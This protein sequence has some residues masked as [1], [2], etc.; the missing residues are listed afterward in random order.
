MS[1]KEVDL[2]VQIVDIGGKPLQVV[3]HACHRVLEHMVDRR[4]RRRR[5][6]PK[7]KMNGKR[8]LKFLYLLIEKEE[9]DKEFLYKR[10]LR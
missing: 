9:A 8:S 2:F 7:L 1:K 10:E 3:I 4:R 5:G 6:Q